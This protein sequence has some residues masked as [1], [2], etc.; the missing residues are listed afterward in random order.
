MAVNIEHE[1]TELDQIEGL[2][3]AAVNLPAASAPARRRGRRRLTHAAVRAA[4]ARRPHAGYAVG[5]GGRAALLARWLLPDAP[6]T[7]C[8][9]ACS[10]PWPPPPAGLPHRA[11]TPRPTG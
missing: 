10:P 4:T 3:Q 8:S 2:R 1:D 6:T 5:R 11:G 7:A 9:W